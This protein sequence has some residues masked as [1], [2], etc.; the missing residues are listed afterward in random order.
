MKLEIKNLIGGYGENVVVNDISFVVNSGEMIYV[1]GPNGGGKTT[2]FNMLIGYKKRMSGQILLEGS[3]IETFSDIELAKQMAYIPQQDVSTFSYT[4]EDVVIMGRAC[5]LKR[6]A[7]PQSHD[8]EI[9]NEILEM[10][11]IARFAKREYTELSGGER[12]LVLIARALC[13]KAK[14]I[15]MDEPLTGLDFAN[16]AMVTKA[17]KELTDVGHTIIM[18]THNAI[19]NYTDDAKILLIDAQGK[20]IFGEIGNIISNNIIQQAY[21][22]P[23]QTI[24]ST[25]ER[26]GRHL[27]CLPV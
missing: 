12:Q 18:S 2:M 26:G 19:N 4:V 23:L 20:S 15:I 14:I 1:L 27:L 8:Y 9:V 7:V 25:D 16:K 22:I 11:G 5:H 6:F 3:D 24:C 17:L 21:N 10:M 13:Q